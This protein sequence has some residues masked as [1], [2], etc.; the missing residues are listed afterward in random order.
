MKSPKVVF[1]KTSSLARVTPETKNTF[2]SIKNHV[3]FFIEAKQ[4][5]LPRHTPKKRFEK[6]QT[7]CTNSSVTD[8]QQ[9]SSFEK[10]KANILF[11]KKRFLGR[12]CNCRTKIK[13]WPRPFLFRKLLQTRGLEGSIMEIRRIYKK[14]FVSHP[15]P[16]RWNTL[17]VLLLI[18]LETADFVV[19]NRHLNSDQAKLKSKYYWNVSGIC[20][21]CARK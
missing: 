20:I 13:R 1:M 16:R 17:I 5:F 10:Y 2:R 9:T 18:L 8:S 7:E 4:Y 21:D 12:I 19:L 11:T 14:G 3:F 6:C 15:T